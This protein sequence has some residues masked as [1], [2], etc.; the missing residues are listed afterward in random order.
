MKFLYL[1]I[2]GTLS[3]TGNVPLKHDKNNVD[4][5]KEFCT[6]II[7]YL[8]ILL[9]LINVLEKG[10]RENKNTHFMFNNFFS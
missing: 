9:I 4:L 3:E 7:M 6:F 8:L 2:F 1:I 10:C 5:H